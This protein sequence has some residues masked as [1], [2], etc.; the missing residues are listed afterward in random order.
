MAGMEHVAFIPSAD[1]FAFTFGGADPVLRI[2]A[3]TVLT[4]WTEDAYGGRIT[5]AD[6]VAS[7]ALDT[8]DLNPQTGPFWIE[9]AEPGDT[10]AV[11]L[12]DLTPARTWGASTLIPF[13]G[14]LTSV[15][16][17]PSLQDPLQERTYIYEYDSAA[18]TLGFSAQGSDFTVDLPVN[19]MLGTV[20]VAPARREVRSSLVREA[21]GGNMKTPEM[22]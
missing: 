3:P 12:A 10:L 17:S 6:D 16:A 21:F 5:S 8:E 2:K 13:F 18:G 1:Q 14:G 7:S 20:G 11:H 19:P 22:A 15:P 9:G 4:L